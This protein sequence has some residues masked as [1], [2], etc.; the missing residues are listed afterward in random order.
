VRLGYAVLLAA[1]VVCGTS[2]ALG[3]D[4][5]EMSL[6]KKVRM[7]DAVVIGQVVSTKPEHSG[8][9]T[10][11]LASVSVS[12]VLKGHPP[13]SI[14]VLSKGPIAEMDPDCCQIGG[15]YLFFLVHDKKGNFESVNGRFGVYPMQAR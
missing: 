14:E 11:E 12:S 3:N 5:R 9:S 4:V 2:N 7:S 13:K 1:C 15:V 6:E 8:E 10:L